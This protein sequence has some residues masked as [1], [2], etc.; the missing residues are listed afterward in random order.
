MVN[1]RRI[2]KKAS[3][4]RKM[5]LL[6]VLLP[7][8]LLLVIRLEHAHALARP[9]L[10][11]RS[12]RRDWLLQQGGAMTAVTTFTTTLTTTACSLSAS[13]ANLPQSYAS[14]SKAGSLETLVPVVQLQAN[15]QALQE[16]FRKDQPKHNNI[17]SSRQLAPLPSSIPKT[18]ASFKAIFDAY[19]VPVSYKQRFVDA[20]AFLVYYTQGFDGPGRPNIEQDLGTLQTQQYG[21]R[22]Q[23]WVA[24]EAVL[25]E[26]NY[27]Q[28]Q[29]SQSSSMSS[30][31]N[32]EWNESI[33]EITTNLAATLRALDEYLDLAPSSVLQLAKQQR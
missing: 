28:Q 18:E 10:G 30:N 7:L 26:Y 32:D 12:S 22:N 20:N 25:S 9:C 1:K 21:A 13:A 17:S 27:V 5:P 14:S 8:L 3:V 16:S 24:W 23:A 29:Q 11:S 6:D 2:I 33:T 19:S 15:L 31:N 4:A